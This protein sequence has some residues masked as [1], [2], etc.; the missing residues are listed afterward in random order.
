MQLSGDLQHYCSTV[1]VDSITLMNFPCSISVTSR[2]YALL[3]ISLQLTS[4][5]SFLIGILS[6]KV[7][8]DISN[9]VVTYLAIMLKNNGPNVLFWNCIMFWFIAPLYQNFKI[10][11]RDSIQ[12]SKHEKDTNLE[13]D[14]ASLPLIENSTGDVEDINK[15]S[16]ETKS[17]KNKHS[18]STNWSG[19]LLCR[20]VFGM[21]ECL[22]CCS[23][24][25]IPDPIQDEHDTRISV[26]YE[27]EECRYVP[28]S[29][30]NEIYM[31]RH[32]GKMLN[33]VLSPNID[34]FGRSRLFMFIFSG[35]TKGTYHSYSFLL[36]F[37]EFYLEQK[38]NTVRSYTF[39]FALISLLLSGIRLK[40]YLYSVIYG[41]LLFPITLAYYISLIWFDCFDLTNPKKGSWMFSILLDYWDKLT[42]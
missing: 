23:Y 4:A 32:P 7:P 15:R 11:R 9:D 33:R 24:I 34:R 39:Y 29:L 12:K 22:F 28:F 6:F 13:K 16:I 35:S 20:I 38:Y 8:T 1:E 10:V 30:Y 41:L 5:I 17:M 27:E 19:F 14:C 25:I 21:L 18:K 42:S 26:G 36:A 3:S 40:V 31:I 37:I 2:H